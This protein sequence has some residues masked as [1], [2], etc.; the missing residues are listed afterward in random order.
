MKKG[1]NESTLVKIVM[2]IM[3]LLLIWGIVRFSRDT[4]ISN[5]TK[6]FGA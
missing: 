3:G 2:A 5:I 6:L 4:G 1:M